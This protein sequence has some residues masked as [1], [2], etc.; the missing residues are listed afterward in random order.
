[1]PLTVN[2]ALLLSIVIGLGIDCNIHVSGRAVQE[3]ERGASLP[4]ALTAVTTGMGGAL[5]GS[6]LTTVTAF[7]RC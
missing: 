5:L 7:P 2:T 1:M 3:L 6:T 4:D